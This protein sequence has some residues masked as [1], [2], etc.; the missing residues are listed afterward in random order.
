MLQSVH[1]FQPINRQ[2]EATFSS[3]P[4][5]SKIGTVKNVDVVSMARIP[6]KSPNLRGIARAYISCAWVSELIANFA[7]VYY[8]TTVYQ[9]SLAININVVINTC[10]SMYTNFGLDRD[11]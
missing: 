8:D 4:P 1:I 2:Y 5:W 11:T 6:D 7:P 9:P 3:L 10:I